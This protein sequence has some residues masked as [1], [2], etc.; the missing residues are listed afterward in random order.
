MCERHYEMALLMS[1]CE[2]QGREI[3]AENVI[4]RMKAAVFA[5]WHI[6][7]SEVA[8]LLQEMGRA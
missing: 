7:E 2:R 1:R 5:V 4:Q 6:A 8:G 3:T